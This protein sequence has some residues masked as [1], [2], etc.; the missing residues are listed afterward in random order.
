ML[1]VPNHR[2][3]AII[4]LPDNSFYGIE[5]RTHILI[6]RKGMG[7]AGNVRNM[8]ADADGISGEFEVCASELEQ[9][10]DYSYWHWKRVATDTRNLT[11]ADIG[12]SIQ[13]GSKSRNFF[14]NSGIGCFHTTELPVA[15]GKINLRK[16]RSQ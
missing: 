5:I 11:L 2:I 14:E 12:A 15:A 9:L 16:S 1:V 10:M 13:R 7:S 6:L 8:Q 3:E 4:Q